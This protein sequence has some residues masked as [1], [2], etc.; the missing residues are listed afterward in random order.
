[1]GKAVRPLVVT[2]NPPLMHSSS[3]AFS[4]IR[5]RTKS[6]I[7]NQWTYRKINV[8]FFVTINVNLSLC[9]SGWHTGLEVRWSSSPLATTRKF[10]VRFTPRPLYSRY[11]LNRRRRGCHSRSRHSGVRKQFLHLLEDEI[12][13]LCS[14]S[15]HLLCAKR[16]SS[17]D[18][19][20]K[21]HQEGE[22]ASY[23][24]A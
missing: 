21:T 7:L 4:W 19:S 22:V 13:E 14:P 6:A 20:P 5:D 23:A 11:P 1:M 9:T 3:I 12:Y 15:L 8:K 2:S 18:F 24:V 16:K 17:F 10:V